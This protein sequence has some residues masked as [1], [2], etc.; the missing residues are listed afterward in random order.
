MFFQQS[1][2]FVIVVPMYD[3]NSAT[4]VCCDE[5]QTKIEM[6]KPHMPFSMV[7]IPIAAVGYSTTLR[8]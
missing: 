4:K 3:N 6:S 2:C 8:L 1:V 5:K 7:S